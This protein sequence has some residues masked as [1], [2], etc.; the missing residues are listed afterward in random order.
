[1]ILPL[2]PL[3][4]RSPTHTISTG[5]TRRIPACTLDPH[6][7]RT[8]PYSAILGAVRTTNTEAA[9]RRATAPG[10]I[11]SHSLLPHSKAATVTQTGALPWLGF[12]FTSDAL[13]V[14]CPHGK[15]G[16]ADVT[17]EGEAFRSDA[18][19]NGFSPDELVYSHLPKPMG[20]YHIWNAPL[21][22]ASAMGVMQHG[23]VAATQAEDQSKGVEREVYVLAKLKGLLGVVKKRQSRI[24]MVGDEGNCDG[25][26]CADEDESDDGCLEDWRKR[27]AR[28]YGLVGSFELESNRSS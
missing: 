12:V 14:A 28:R 26:S 7:P 27:D 15:P 25:G 20:W 11:P 5:I 10:F 18:F 13:P 2:A 6:T 8:R 4:G 23:E 19:G 24:G 3:T 9:A 16:H 17:A 1:M 21:G 22:A